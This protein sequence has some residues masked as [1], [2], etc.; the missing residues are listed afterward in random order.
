MIY[1]AIHY[2]ESIRY[3]SIYSSK[4]K[5]ILPSKSRVHALAGAASPNA[6]STI[7]R[8]YRMLLNSV[9]INVIPSKKQMSATQ[10]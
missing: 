6:S 7:H 8:A 3:S 1:C 10:S 4:A 9:I 2:S 5:A